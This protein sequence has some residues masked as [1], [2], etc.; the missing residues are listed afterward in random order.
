MRRV[1][2]LFSCCCPEFVRRCAPACASSG[3]IPRLTPELDGQELQRDPNVELGHLT[4]RHAPCEALGGAWAVHRSARA[5][6]GSPYRECLR[7]F[8]GHRV[9]RSDMRLVQ[10]RGSFETRVSVQNRVTDSGSTTLR[11]AGVLTCSL[12]G[13]RPATSSLRSAALGSSSARARA[14]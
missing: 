10:L 8:C 7:P 4:A 2:T 11:T 3:A 14:C 12:W 1:K 5:L 13:V 9:G 6:H